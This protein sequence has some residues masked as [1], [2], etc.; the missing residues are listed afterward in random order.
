VYCVLAL[1]SIRSGPDTFVPHLSVTLAL[2]LALLDLGV[3]IYF[4]HHVA[5]SIQLNEVIAGIGGDLSLAIEDE[6]RLTAP[7]MGAP[8]GAEDR[9][10]DEIERAGAVIPSTR[11]GYLQ[12]VSLEDVMEIAIRED[13]TIQILHR[14][15]HFVTAGGP[16]ARV[17]P[18]AR[19]DVVARALDR[20]HVTGRHRTLTQDPV[21]AVDQLVEIAIRALSPAVNDTFTA[22]TCIDWLTDG[23]CRM[24]GRSFPEVVHHDHGGRTRL[25]HPGLSYRRVVD[26]AFDKIRQAAPG[27][28]AVLIRQ[29]ESLTR[30][31]V[32]TPDPQGRSALRR[33]ADMIMRSS[34]TSVP[35]PED[36][37]AVAQRYARAAAALDAPP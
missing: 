3:L 26:R 7:G 11:S 4:I 14:P 5:V 13:V 28:P 15:G 22:L 19:A 2:G 27:M 24:T 1:A 18:A 10:L 25:I 37:G 6:F 9:T 34:E 31:A 16:L 23:L 33:Q 8:A 32:V 21:F 30:I 12:V 20:A 29:L 36:R 17:L 35:E